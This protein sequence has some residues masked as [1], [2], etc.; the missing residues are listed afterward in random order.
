MSESGRV[1]STAK[2]ISRAWMRRLV[3]IFFRLNIILLLLVA[4]DAIGHTTMGAQR[5]LDI[6]PIRLQPSEMMKVALVLM[7]AA[8]YDWLD[9]NKVSRPLWVLIPILLILIPTGLVVIQ[10]DLG[11]AIML[12]LGG[13]FTAFAAGVSVTPFPP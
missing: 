5:W 11:T 13:A 4:V 2:K 6:G 9:I 10:P 8:Y 3:W 1:T 7:L 12:T